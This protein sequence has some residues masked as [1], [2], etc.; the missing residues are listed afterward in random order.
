MKVKP[1]LRFF[2]YLVFELL[3]AKAVP[4]RPRNFFLSKVA[5]FA[6]DIEIDL[7]MIFCLNDCFLLDS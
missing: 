1:Y 7:T 4:I 6:G 2:G 3:A 5:K